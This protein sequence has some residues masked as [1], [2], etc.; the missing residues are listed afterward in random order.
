MFERSLLSAALILAAT[1]VAAQ[2]GAQKPTPGR[3]Q[4]PSASVPYQ[5]AIMQPRMVT[6]VGCLQHKQDYILTEAMVQ[7][8]NE[9]APAQAAPAAAYKIEGL[10]SARLVLLVNK[11]VEVIGAYQEPVKGAAAG[12]T[13]LARFEAAN[14]NE[15]ADSCSPK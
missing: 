8:Q 1:S 11:R 2:S 5:P 15:L 7:G 4:A 10:S 9:K 13:S 3:T 12:T 6:L 14:I